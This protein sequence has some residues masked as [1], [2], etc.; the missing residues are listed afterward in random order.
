MKVFSIILPLSFAMLVNVFVVAFPGKHLFPK[1]VFLSFSSGTDSVSLFASSRKPALIIVS[2]F[3]RY[4]SVEVCC[5]VICS[6]V[7]YPAHHNMDLWHPLA[8]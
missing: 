8:I 6:A 1:F 3:S 7:E 5:L 4:L 2:Y